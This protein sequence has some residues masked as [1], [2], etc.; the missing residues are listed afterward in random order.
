MIKEEKAAHGNTRPGLEGNACTN[1][2]RPPVRADGS[3]MK[4]GGADGA[5]LCR[6]HGEV[7]EC[8]SCRECMR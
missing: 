2:Q 4:S 5:R 7:A 3:G 8:H 6:L 1:C